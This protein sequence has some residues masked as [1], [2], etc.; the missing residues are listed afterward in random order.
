MKKSSKIQ[1]KRE[2]QTVSL[3]PCLCP[4]EV[5]GRGRTRL[6]AFPFD[7]APDTMSGLK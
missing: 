4:K 2:S 5:L 6:I 1:A 3:V 7:R